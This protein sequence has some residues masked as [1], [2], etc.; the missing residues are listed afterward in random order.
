MGEIIDAKD[1]FLARITTQR[2]ND[3]LRKAAEEQEKEKAENER[4]NENRGNG[5]DS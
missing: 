2:M 3:I 1:I 4:R 5:R